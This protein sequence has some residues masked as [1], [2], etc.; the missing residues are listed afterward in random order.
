MEKFINSNIQYDENIF[1]LKQILNSI[2]RGVN[3]NI[4]RGLF[5]KKIK[6]DL[7]FINKCKNLLLDKLLKNDKLISR[8]SLL[9]K[10]NTLINKY[11]DISDKIFELEILKKADFLPII[12]KNVADHKIINEIISK[13]DS[14]SFKEDLTTNQELSILLMDSDD[15]EEN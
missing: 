8:D 4:N 1:Y 15:K 14:D 12:E 5:Q 7:I 13:A 3:N 10:I 11:A 9:Q 2:E 6:D